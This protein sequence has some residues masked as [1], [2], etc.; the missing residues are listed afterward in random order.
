MVKNVNIAG[1]TRSDNHA[2][3]GLSNAREADAVSIALV[4]TKEYLGF[5]PGAIVY[6]YPVV[7]RLVRHR[8]ICGVP[9]RVDC[10]IRG[11]PSR[12]DGTLR[13]MWTRLLRDALLSCEAPIMIEEYARMETGT[14]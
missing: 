4:V 2:D 1:A 11:V 7:L 10:A 13:C 6:P 3:N 12:V 8:A 14:G 9:S 5:R